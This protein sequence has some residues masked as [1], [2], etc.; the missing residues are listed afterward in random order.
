MPPA[1]LVAAARAMERAAE[2]AAGQGEPYATRVRRELL[3]PRH[4]ILLH[5]DEAHAFCEQARIPWPWGGSRADAARRWVADARAAGVRVQRE[6]V[7]A[8][9][10]ATFE[11]YC[12]AL[13]AEPAGDSAK[14]G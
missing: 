14:N 6:K 5:W 12:A 8:E 2:A 11:E 9:A 4:A 1:T 3:A 10:A 7:A 13:V